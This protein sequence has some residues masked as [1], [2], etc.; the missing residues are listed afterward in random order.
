MKDYMVQK[1]DEFLANKANEMYNE[2]KKN[3]VED[4]SLMDSTMLSHKFAP[5][6]EGINPAEVKCEIA[7]LLQNQFVFNEKSK[8]QHFNKLSIPCVR[9]TFSPY[10]FLGYDLVHVQALE[11]LNG[12]SKMR[13]KD[14]EEFEPVSSVWTSFN[15]EATPP[16][17]MTPGKINQDIVHT[18]SWSF[19]DELNNEIIRDLLNNAPASFFKD[20]FSGVTQ[21]QHQIKSATGFVPNWIV[22]G[23]ELLNRVILNDKRDLPEENWKYIK[24]WNVGNAILNGHKTKVIISKNI[25]SNQFLMGYKGEYCGYGFFPYVTCNPM[26]PVLD[27]DSFCPKQYFMFRRGKR[28]FKEGKHFY[29]KFSV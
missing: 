15:F 19:C 24:A 29:H 17:W 8:D 18:S 14:S 28:L 5:L 9:S 7:Q 12:V 1:M 11:G 6:L 25:V 10:N 13:A 26:S 27:P 4:K 23:E 2:A 3:V 21:A 22:G 16:G 20:L